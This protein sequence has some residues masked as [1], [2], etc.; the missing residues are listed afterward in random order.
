MS[1]M[2]LINKERMLQERVSA[3]RHQ[4]SLQNDAVER[5]PSSRRLSR[6]CGSVSGSLRERYMNESRRSSVIGMAR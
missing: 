1:V 5:H 6:D 3:V 4:Y 2:D